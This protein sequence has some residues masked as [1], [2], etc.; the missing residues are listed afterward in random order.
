[1]FR[2]WIPVI[3]TFTLA[4]G[5]ESSHRTVLV[6]AG[7]AAGVAGASGASASGGSGSGG[8]GGI[9]NDGGAGSGGSASGG[10]AGDAGSAGTGNVGGVGGSAGSAAGSA[11]GGTG[12]TCVPKTCLTIAYEKSGGNPEAEACGI[13]SD[14][15]GNVI[16]CGGCE[17]EYAE[18]SSVTKMCEG[19]CY[20][21]D[22]ASPC[23]IL[24][25]SGYHTWCDKE[26]TN[27]PFINCSAYGTA[28]TKEWC[29]P[30]Q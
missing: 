30:K 22:D 28:P 14:G 17:W 11:S 10:A 24:Q 19:N 4:C 12:G 25:L 7:G 5:S 15:C 13:V 8:S 27:P 16:D 29:C 6:N 26:G 2:Y 1:M 21:S 23:Q 20:V 9:E 18:C 3:A